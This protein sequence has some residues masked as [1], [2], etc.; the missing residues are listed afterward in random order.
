[1]QL[2]NCPEC[3]KVFTFIRTN[4]CPECQKED[5]ERFKIV[6]KYI[7]LHRGV[8]I[9]TVSEETGIKETNI[10]RYLRE[11]RILSG[12]VKQQALKCELCGVRI[13]GG[14][15]CESCNNKLTSGIKKVM[16]DENEKYLQEEANKRKGKGSGMFTADM[17]KKD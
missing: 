3:G 12:E 8:S 6:R 13:T 4:L 10:L 9:G 7:A 1:M 14:R 5:E 17:R 16:R 11:G 2:K 15:Y